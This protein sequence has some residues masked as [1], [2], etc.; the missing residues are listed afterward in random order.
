MSLYIA[1][2]TY[3]V[4]IVLLS[5]IRS[6]YPLVL[7]AFISIFMSL[8]INSLFDST[9]TM[10]TTTFTTTG[11]LAWTQSDFMT[12][13]YISLTMMIFAKAAVMN[14]SKKSKEMENKNE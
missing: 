13:L 2:I 1:V 12:L 9:G 10:A 5:C 4:M 7:F 3:I 14:F 11:G 8:S 6:T